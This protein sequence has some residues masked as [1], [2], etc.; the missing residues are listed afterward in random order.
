MSADLR[1]PACGEAMQQIEA[2]GAHVQIC[3]GCRGLW[4]SRAALG[5][6]GCDLPSHRP[7]RERAPH[8]CP[9]CRSPLDR[10]DAHVA[11]LELCWGCGGMFLEAAQ[12][13]AL[14]RHSGL[15][16]IELRPAKPDGELEAPPL[17]DPSRRPQVFWC[18]FCHQATPL[19]E[20]VIA[21]RVT[22]CAACA[23]RHGLRHDPR[24]RQNAERENERANITHPDDTEYIVRAVLR[25][26]T[27]IPFL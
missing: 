3:G 24:A 6:L 19:E 27:G 13:A 26:L 12:F 5:A 21:E 10:R 25:V 23:K 15:A 22:A 9:A 8:A 17:E 1:C 20:Q 14:A 18:D 16:K 11:F 2:G 4:L 7:E